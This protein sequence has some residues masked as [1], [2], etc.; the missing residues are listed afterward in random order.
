MGHVS[1][2]IREAEERLNLLLDVEATM[3]RQG[4]KV[5]WHANRDRNTTYFHAFANQRRRNNL[6][7][8]IMGHDGQWVTDVVEIVNFIENH[9]HDV[10]VSARPNEVDID[11]ILALIKSKVT[12]E[13][14]HELLKTYTDDD[15]WKALKDIHP[16]RSPGP[17]GYGLGFYQKHW[18]IVGDAVCKLV[19]G[20]L[21]HVSF[22]ILINGVRSD[23]FTQE[24]GIG[25]GDPLS[26]ILY[27]MC[28][29]GLTTMLDI[30]VELGLIRGVAASKTRDKV[31][32]M[33]KKVDG[34]V[35]NFSKSSL[36]FSKNVSKETQ[37]LLKAKLEISKLL[38]DSTYLGLPI[39][40]RRKEQVNFEYLRD[41]LPDSFC[42]NLEMY[43]AKFFW[44]T[45]RQRKIHWATW[46]KLSSYGSTPSDIWRGLIDSREVMLAG[47][48]WRVGNG[49]DVTWKQMKLREFFPDAVVMVISNP[50]IA[51]GDFVE[52]AIATSLEVLCLEAVQRVTR[53]SRHLN[54]QG[55]NLPSHCEICLDL[56]ESILHVIRDC[57]WAA[58][59]WNHLN[60]AMICHYAVDNLFCWL[61]DVFNML[62]SKQLCLFIG[63]CWKI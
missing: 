50:P 55:I 3:W 2:A 45:D 49:A 29:E 54:H 63:A 27:V 30:K 53:N 62:S 19:L 42:E 36:F 35:V 44:G 22:S 34:R 33:Y 21:N 31:L 37:G 47:G 32:E 16:N 6:V 5:E 1:P 4:S 61:N 52:V 57:C 20:V 46:R 24:R 38:G 15:V 13:V 23:R 7:K 18:A 60:L 28:L 14:N 59:V 56:E 58:L 10:Y 40:I 17:D 12:V 51:L 26:P 39:I 9:F 11:S 43:C 8:R 41:R 25:Q 48:H